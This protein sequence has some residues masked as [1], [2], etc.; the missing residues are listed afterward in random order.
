MSPTSCL[1]P[2]RVHRLTPGT[3][4]ELGRKETGWVEH[5]E[6]ASAA[7]ALTAFLPLTA[8][9]ILGTLVSSFALPVGQ[10]EQSWTLLLTGSGLAPSLKGHVT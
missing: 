7:L 5:R 4:K 9:L 2:G 8:G 6:K 1:V 3:K 10:R